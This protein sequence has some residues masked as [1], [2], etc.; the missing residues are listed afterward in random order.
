MMIG[1]TLESKSDKGNYYDKQL[2]DRRKKS[3]LYA[4]KLIEANNVPITE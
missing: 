1:L 3:L 2:I 4:I